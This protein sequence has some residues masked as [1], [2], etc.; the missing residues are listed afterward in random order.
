MWFDDGFNQAIEK[1]AW[2]SSL[3]LLEFGESFNQPVEKIAWPPLLEPLDF[4]KYR[5]LGP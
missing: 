4:V 5:D 1:V 3:R 2:P